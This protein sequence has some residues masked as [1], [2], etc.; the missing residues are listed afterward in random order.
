M[1][2]ININGSIL[3]LHSWDCGI[4]LEMQLQISVSRGWLQSPGVSFNLETFLR[5]PSVCT[6]GRYSSGWHIPGLST[7]S[8][9]LMPEHS[10]A[11]HGMYTFSTI[12][13]A[14]RSH[15]LGN[16]WKWST[17]R[18]VLDS[19]CLIG[20]QT[21]PKLSSVGSSPGKTRAEGQWRKFWFSTA[22]SLTRQR[23]FSVDFRPS[24]VWASGLTECWKC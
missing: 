16:F 1:L 7:H 18:L 17:C 24:K 5:L 8:I 4:V 22:L 20:D 6:H 11:A 23:F 9:S 21:I 15:Q 3:P 19:V 13:S 12:G 10:S 2:N 14:N